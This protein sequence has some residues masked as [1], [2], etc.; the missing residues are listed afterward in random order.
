MFSIIISL[1]LLR[2]FSYSGW[3]VREKEREEKR[4]GRAQ[5][6][7]MSYVPYAVFSSLTTHMLFSSIHFYQISFFSYSLRVFFVSVFRKVFVSVNVRCLMLERLRTTK[8]ISMVWFFPCDFQGYRSFS[9]QI[10]SNISYW[11][12]IN[13]EIKQRERARAR[14]KIRVFFSIDDNGLFFLA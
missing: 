2:F 7:N 6:K 13:I 3:C 8:R 12:V 14:I 5:E 1:Y 4:A 10:I 11:H 9:M